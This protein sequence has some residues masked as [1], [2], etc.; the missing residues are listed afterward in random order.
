[1]DEKQVRRLLVDIREPIEILK[2]LVS[3]YSEKEKAN[4]LSGRIVNSLRSQD[5]AGTLMLFKLSI[6][7]I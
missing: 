6:L 5:L 3:N 4:F 7:K 2:K 1:V